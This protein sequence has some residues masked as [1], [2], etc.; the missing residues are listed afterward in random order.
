MKTEFIMLGG[1]VM[2]FLAV[3]LGS[4][5]HDLLRIERALV[6]INQTLKDR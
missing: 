1:L 2:G 6:T 4:L 5:H 3:M